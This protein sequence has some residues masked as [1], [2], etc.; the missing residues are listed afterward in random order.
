MAKISIILPTYNV[1][2]YIARALESCINQTFKDIEIIVVDDCGTDRSIDIA[3]E[4]AKN[5]TRIKIIYNE[6]NLG[7][8]RARYE[9]VKISSSLF[10]MFLDPDDYL[11]FDACKN[12]LNFIDNSS[13]VDLLFFNA[14][15]EGSII[16]YKKFDFDSGFYSKK[17][18]IKKIIAKKNL[19]W[20]M[21]GKLI[22]KEL[23]LEAFASLRLEQDVKI[24]M[25]EDVL[26]YYPMLNQAQEIGYMNDNLYHYMLNND[27]ICNTKNK[28]LIENNIKEQYLVLNYLKQNYISNKYCDILYVL[29]KYLLYIQIYKARKEKFITLL[30]SK[31]NILSL[32]ILFK[33][34]KNSRE[35]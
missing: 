17:E 31:I 6:K 8:L 24:N 29:I 19:Y 21:W 32:K 34:K 13:G 10:I 3:K 23:Y 20:T 35:C 2:K 14:I 4:Y 9:G 1:E 33:Y 7:L 30:F 26:L 27:S 15:V 28:L 11:E 25:A 22:R 12:I 18:F 5:D 16:S